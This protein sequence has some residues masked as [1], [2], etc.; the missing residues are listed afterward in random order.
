MLFLLAGIL[1]SGCGS[2][3]V[4]LEEIPSTI[5]LEEVE[6]APHFAIEFSCGP[7]QIFACLVNRKHYVTLLSYIDMNEEG[8]H[9]SSQDPGVEIELFNELRNGDLI[10]RVYS[11]TASEP[12]EVSFRYSCPDLTGMGNPIQ[13]SAPKTLNFV[14]ADYNFCE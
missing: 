11:F 6:G 2:D 14:E 12:G 4:C 8:C 7:E 5:G 9:F 13:T 3:T 1:T 10:T